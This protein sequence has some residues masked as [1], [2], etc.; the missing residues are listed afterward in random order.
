MSEKVVTEIELRNVRIIFKN[1]AGEKT[2][3]NAAGSRNFAVVIDDP[4]YALEL[5]EQGWNIKELAPRD[6]GDLPTYFLQVKIAFNAYPPVVYMVT[7]QTKTALNEDTISSLD[8]A[9][10][11]N[12]NI[13]IRPYTY[14][15]RGLSG[16]AA[17]AKYL[18][19]VIEE[20][21]FASMYDHLN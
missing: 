1:F 17:Y 15:V 5:R 16:I 6:E 11:K 10:I 18:Y 21:P 3:Y 9:E 14:E 2:P 8:Y 7:S 4:D 13:V 12:A 20:D 19:V